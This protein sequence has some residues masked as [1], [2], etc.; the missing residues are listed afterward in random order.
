MNSSRLRKWLILSAPDFEQR[1]EEGLQKLAAVSAADPWCLGIYIDNELRWYEPFVHNVLTG[2]PDM[3][4]RTAVFAFL[5]KKY[6]SI[7]A[8]NAAWGTNYESWE[9]LSAFPEES[10]GFEGDLKSLKR[11]IANRYY[12]VCHDMMRKVFPN[13]LYLGSRIH[14][15]PPEVY[16]E[17]TRF[18]DVLSVNRYMPLAASGLPKG[19]DKPCIVSEFHFAAPD[20]GVPGVGLTYVGDQLQRSRAYAAY[21]LDSVNQP[22]IVGTHWFAYPDQSAT[23]KISRGKP[24]VNGNIGFVDVTDTPYPE[25]TAYS[26]GLAD[27]MYP[28]ADKESVDVL[29]L[30]QDTWGTQQSASKPE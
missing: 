20:R 19:F 5:Q 25:I 21:V 10:A 14:K 18:T 6:S 15:A 12:K 24:A 1:V 7:E 17:S 8:L 23:G 9:A 26:R 27:V 13:H 29:Q 30:L 2:S 3:P 28:L 11:L 4:A 16:E 22:N